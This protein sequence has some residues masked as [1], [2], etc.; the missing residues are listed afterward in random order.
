MNTY[1]NGGKKGGKGELTLSNDTVNKFINYI[2]GN[3]TKSPYLFVVSNDGN[4]SIYFY[5]PSGP[6]NCRG[7]DEA[8]LTQCQ[9]YSNDIDC[10]LFARTRTIMW[11][12]NINRGDK[13]SKIN[14]DNL[15][16]L[17]QYYELTEEL[18]K[19]THG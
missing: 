1:V 11:K 6:N 8:A 16:N 10:S 18:S 13:N 19:T 14:N 4:T 17:L 15:I 9:R 5:C 2:R 7:G 12:N 3:F